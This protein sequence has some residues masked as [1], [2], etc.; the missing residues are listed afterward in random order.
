MRIE[1]VIQVK[2]RLKGKNKAPVDRTVFL[3][4]KFCRWL[5]LTPKKGQ[6]TTNAAPLWLPDPDDDDDDDDEEAG[7]PP[8]ADD[9][10]DDN[11]DG[12][13]R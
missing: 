3:N 1:D 5:E 11:D 7:P 10:D 2:K 9:D 12:R 8:P 6:A 4:G 13:R